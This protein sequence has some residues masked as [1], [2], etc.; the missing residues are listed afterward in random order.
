MSTFTA[1]DVK[2]RVP[3]VK[4]LH[5]GDQSQ[6]GRYSFSGTATASSIVKFF[7]VPNGATIEDIQFSGGPG[8]GSGV[9]VIG[10]SASP[11]CILTATSISAAVATVRGELA[12]ATLPKLISLSDDA[13]PQ[14]VW[15][16]GKIKSAGTSYSAGGGILRLHGRYRMDV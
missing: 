14:H 15:I 6:Y 1:V 5:A 12:A 16:Q 8:D 9:I 10:T 4:A 2:G 7:R 13:E 11:S 3:E